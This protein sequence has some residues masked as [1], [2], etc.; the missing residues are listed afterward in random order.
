MATESVVDVADSHPFWV[1]PFPDI[2]VVHNGH[3][4]NE[5]KLRR[6]LGSCRAEFSGTATP[7]RPRI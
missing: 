3:I 6:R 2:S 1:R 7:P 4:T 5:H